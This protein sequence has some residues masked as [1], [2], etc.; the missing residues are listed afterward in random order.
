MQYSLIATIKSRYETIRSS[1]WFIPA[2]MTGFVVLLSFGLLWLDR[3]YAAEIA[4][5]TP[6]LFGGTASSAQDILS[7]IAS[8]V[9]TVV[10]IAFSLTIVA[11]QQASAQYTPRV[12]RNFTSDRG[13][14]IVLGAYI[15]TFV[16]S[17]LILRA[18]RETEN[19]TEG[20]IPSIAVGVAVLLVLVCIGMLIYFINHIASSLQASTVISRVHQELL[21]QINE[22][23]PK[24]IGEATAQK[25]QKTV[26]PKKNTHAIRSKKGGFVTSIEEDG[27]S[28]KAIDGVRALHILPKVGDFV[29]SG[30]VIAVAVASTEPLRAATEKI[31]SLVVI[32]NNRSIVQDPLFAVRQLVDTALKGLSPGINDTTTSNYCVRYLGDALGILANREFPSSVRVIPENDL[33]VYL[34]KPTWDV[35]VHESF[36]QII[37]AAND[38]GQVIE[39]CLHTLNRLAAVIPYQD[40]TK[41]VRLLLKDIDEI[42]AGKQLSASSKKRIRLLLREIRSTLDAVPSS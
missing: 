16:Y 33:K 13:N 18:V 17:L 10:S 6:W 8:A 35:F 19:G 42:V 4:T 14:Q 32:T 37:Q 1:L 41:P 31:R 26:T 9:I 11:M 38:N 28:T 12:L 40:R 25:S 22:L 5:Q 20:F 15:A 29:A 23:Y 24:H 34:A 7:T 2:L 3:T 30:E 39:E 21:E 36:S 27:F